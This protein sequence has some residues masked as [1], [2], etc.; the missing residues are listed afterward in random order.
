M[1][2][3]V[4]SQIGVGYHFFCGTMEHSLQHKLVADGYPSDMISAICLQRL[5]NDIPLALVC[6]V[7]VVRYWVVSKIDL[8]VHFCPSNGFELGENGV[9]PSTT[10]T[11]E[12]KN[13][14]TPPTQIDCSLRHRD[15]CAV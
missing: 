6:R 14:N 1:F 11:N 9:I 3:D 4:A 13:R 12:T 8:H 2:G 7:V 5:L 10:G 15:G